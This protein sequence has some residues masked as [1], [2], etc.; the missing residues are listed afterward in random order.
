MDGPTQII[1]LRPIKSAD[2]YLYHY[3]R[4]DTAIQHILATGTL[5]MSPFTAV[6]DPWEAIH[7]F[8]EAL[9]NDAGDDPTA[10]EFMMPTASPALKGACKLLCF[11]RDAPDA[12]RVPIPPIDFDPGTV[13]Y[14]GFCRP[15][16]WAQYASTIGVSDGVCLVFDA[17]LLESAIATAL[18]PAAIF[19]KGDI[20]YENRITHPTPEL[21][22]YYD[23]IK[24]RGLDAVIA[25]HL[26]AHWRA[27]FFT[28]ATDWRDERE[29]RYFVANVPA[30]YF[31]FPFKDA[32]RAVVVGPDF[33]EHQK[34]HLID[35]CIRSFGVRPSQLF[36]QNGYPQPYSEILPPGFKSHVQV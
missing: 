25:D 26:K 32:L 29:F 36:W 1:H 11:T 24:V 35:T 3:T 9:L 22:F 12:T 31:L 6:N 33:P 18:P 20:R 27:L 30:D 10:L 4:A 16:M 19:R 17:A 34:A 23:Q 15:R 7:W 5:R 8:V 2:Q 13:W 28:K 21:S 14:R